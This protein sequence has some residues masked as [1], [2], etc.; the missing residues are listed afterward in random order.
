MRHGIKS[1]LEFFVLTTIPTEPMYSKE[2]IARL[3]FAGCNTSE[4]TLYPLLN[5]LKR[6]GLLEAQIEETDISGPPRKYYYLTPKGRTH[7]EKLNTEWKKLH[8]TLHKLRR[9]P[10]DDR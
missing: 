10:S 2:I 9:S 7:L 5:E 6:S 4:G 1:F 3:K 8:D